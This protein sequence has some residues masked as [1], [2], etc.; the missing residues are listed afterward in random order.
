MKK[1]LVLLFA[2]MVYF[3]AF[4]IP[5][6]P[7][8]VTINQPNGEELTIIPKGDEYI[9]WS[10]TLDGY[11]LLVNSD[12]YYCYAQLNASGDLE[13]SAI[14]ATEIENRTPEVSAWLQSIG[15]NL[16]YSDEQVYYYMQFRAISE[17]EMGKSRAGT[18]GINKVPIILVQ[19]PDVQYKKTALDFDL[20][21]NQI[22][23]YENG[24]KG[25]FKDYFL[26]ASYNKLEVQSTVFGP[27]MLDY[28]LDPYYYPESKWWTFAQHSIQKAVAG[29]VDFTPFTV[30]GNQIEGVYIIYAG[31]DQ[32][33]NEG[34][35]R[36]WAHAQLSF[37]YNYGGFLF[38]RYAASSELEGNSGSALATIGTF[39]HEYGHVLGAKDFYDTN[40]KTGGQYE[41]TGYWDL[42]ASG[43]HLS[44]GRKPSTP[45]PRSKVYTYGWATVTELSTPQRCTIPAARI[46]DNAY[47]RINT[48]ESNQYFML[49]F[50]N[51]KGFDENIYGK[52]MLIY[53]CTETYE[54]S[55]PYQMNTTSWQRFYPVAANA[56]VAVPGAGSNNQSQY[57]NI[58]SNTCTWPTSTKTSFDDTTIPAMV[59][60]DG[61]GVGKPIS[62]IKA[63]EDYVT[64]D[65]MGGGDRSTFHVFLPTYYGLKIVPQPGSVS[66]VNKG[67]SFSFKIEILPSHNQSKLTVTSNNSAITPFSNIYTISN[68]Q[69]D[70]IVRITGLAFNQFDITAGVENAGFITPEGTIKVNHGGIQSFEIYPDNGYSIDKVVVDGTNKGKIE[71]YTFYNVL[72][73]HNIK[74]I[75][76]KGDKYTINTSADNFYFETETGVPSDHVVV[77]VSSP[78]V[79]ASITV[80]APNRFK[81]SS[82]KGL[83]WQQGFLISKNKLP[84]E[85]W[86][87]FSP[88]AGS[89]NAGTF[90]EV[91]K[92]KSQEAYAEIKLTGKSWVGINEFANENMIT[93]YPNP[94]TGKLRIENGELRIEKIE[95]Y[96]IYGRMQK[97]ERSKEQ[98]EGEMV[99]DISNLSAGVYMIKFDTDK[100]VIHKKVVK[101]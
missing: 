76:K 12:A 86:I 80:E 67:G 89:S 92:L 15:K 33:A 16:F 50:K 65:F 98:G 69:D 83:N 14:M 74:A 11:T 7:K 54:T 44:G 70:Q 46:Y 57:G 29:G 49:E 6:D 75:F 18:T 56:P 10:E 84:C 9:H 36:I 71:S 61:T 97:E 94:T 66:P 62:N 3:Q 30:S 100:G 60:W 25:S 78:D 48:P 21:F 53:K 88:P 2:A 87:R 95:I 39:C 1:L 91:L 38:K 27:F 24:F 32:S 47:F 43:A 79:V 35:K 58:N 55:T 40:Y 42:Q 17:Q 4:A 90:D 28:Q 85:V 26:E 23:Y 77:T 96:D 22:N 37:N 34:S 8:P 72:E 68:I 20:L 5:A 59:T 63:F 51:Q 45:N 13:P 41:G 52:N 19:F 73:P 99:I 93:I 81:V 82:D 31:Y 64:F 101:E